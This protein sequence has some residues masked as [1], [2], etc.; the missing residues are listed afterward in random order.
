VGVLENALRASGGLD[1]WRLTRRF[2]IH[3][4]ITGDLCSTKCSSA[5]L[6]ELVVEDVERMDVE[7]NAPIC[8]REPL[9]ADL[10]SRRDAR[11]HR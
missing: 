9:Y 1:L 6:K 5:K 3:M 10:L 7:R 4:S 8:W 2:I 11:L